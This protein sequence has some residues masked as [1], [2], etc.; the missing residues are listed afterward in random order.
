MQ[1]GL[2]PQANVLGGRAST[3]RATSRP[4]A[5]AR[6]RASARRSPP[7]EF[8]PQL[9]AIDFSFK[10]DCPTDFDCTPP[11]RLPAEPADAARHRLSRQGLRQL[12][13][14]DARPDR[15][16]WR[17]PGASASRQTSAIALV[18][19]LAYVG[20]QIALRARTPRT[21]AYLGPRA[22]TRSRCGGSPA[23]RLPHERGAQRAR[24]RAYR[25]S[26][27]RRAAGRAT[28][29]GDPGGHRIRHAGS[30]VPGRGSPMPAVLDGARAVFEARR[31]LEAA[32][33]RPT[34]AMPSTPGATGAAA[35]PPAPPRDAGRAL[36]NL[37]V[38]DVLVFEE[39]RRAAHRQRPPTPTRPT[40][41][42]AADVGAGLSSSTAAAA[43]RSADRRRNHRDRL[44]R[45]RRA[46]VPAL[47][48][49]RD[50]RGVRPLFTCRGCQRR[51][52][53]HRARR[54]WPDRRGR[55]A[56]R[57]A[58]PALAWA[59]PRRPLRAAAARPRPTRFPPRFRPQLA[60]R[61][62]SHAAARTPLTAAAADAR[63][64]A[65]RAARA[66]P[67]IALPQRARRHADA[68]SGRV[69]DLL[70]SGPFAAHFV[71]EIED[72][73]RA[74]LRFGD[75]MHGLRP[76]SGTT[77]D[78]S[79]RVGNGARRQHRRGHARHVARR[80]PEIAAV[81]NPLPAVGGGEPETH[82]SGA[83]PRALR[84]PP[85]GA[86]GHPRRTTRDGAPLPP[87]GGAS[88]RVRPQRHT[89]SWHTVF[90]TVDRRGGLPVDRGLR[91]PTCARTSSATGW[92]GATSRSTGRATCRSRSSSWSAS[93]RDY[94]RGQVKRRCCGASQQ[95]VL[96]DGR[97]GLFHPDRFSFGQTLYLCPLYRAA[98]RRS[99]G[100]TSV[101]STRFQR[102]GDAG[103]DGLDAGKLRFGR[104]RD[105][106]ARQRP[107]TSPSAAGS[108]SCS[109]AGSERDGDRVPGG[110]CGCCEGIASRPRPARQPAGAC[111]DLGSGSATAASFMRRMLARL[112][113]AEHGALSDLSD[114]RPTTTSRSHCIDAWA[115]VG[116]I[117]TFY[118]ER[119]AAEALL[120]HRERAAVRCT[121][122]RGWSATAASGRRRR[123]RPRL[124]PGAT[125]AGPR[126]SRQLAAR[127]ARCR[128]RPGPGETPV[129]FETSRR[130]ARP[131]GMRMRPRLSQPQALTASDDRLWPAGTRPAGQRRR[132]VSFADRRRR[133]RYSRSSAGRRA[134]TRRPRSDPAPSISRSSRSTGSRRAAPA[135]AHVAP[136]PPPAPACR[137][138]ARYFGRD[139]IDAARASGRTLEAAK[140]G[141]EPRSSHP[142]DGLASR[143][144]RIRAPCSVCARAC[145]ATTRRELRRRCRPSLTGD[146]PIFGT[147]GQGGIIITGVEP[148][149]YKNETDAVGGQHA[150]RSLDERR[151][152][153]RILDGSL[154]GGRTPASWRGA[155]RRRRLGPLPRRAGGRGLAK[156]LHDLAKA[157]RAAARQRRPGSRTLSDPRDHRV[158]RP[159]ERSRWRPASPIPCPA[160]RRHRHRAEQLR[161]RARARAAARADAAGR[162]GGGR[163]VA[164]AEI[165][166]VE[167]RAASSPAAARA[168]RFARRWLATTA[169]TACGSTP[170][171]PRH[172]RREL[173]RSPRQ[174][175]TP[176]RP[177]R[178][179]A[180]QQK[181]LTH[182]TAPV[183]DGRRADARGLGQRHPVAARLRTSSTAAAEER[184]STSPATRRGRPH[185]SS[186][187]ATA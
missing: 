69:R 181:P 163:A 78:A 100:S 130:S 45:R 23:R 165:A 127:D 145:S 150:R 114:P 22:A 11:A 128:A 6:A 138:P 137:R 3:G 10:V 66:P 135:S 92:P 179:F 38:G 44:G 147:D 107:E 111:G 136:P 41:A 19:L 175:A 110:I 133:H 20:D 87:A 79:Y 14:A 32:L 104:L 5:A 157:T 25:R 170:T 160:R 60:A 40:A 64:G 28:S 123:R 30:P 26:S 113:S 121:S 47:P 174:P 37:A 143:P 88:G 101:G 16:R 48:L 29:P 169:A 158:R 15:R 53:Q 56:R 141:D 124:P 77:F 186:R 34:T 1:T 162:R 142:L 105:R 154:P 119:L 103:Q 183:A 172:A 148:G 126:S 82:R 86:R 185:A 117:L 122:W 90:V 27:A 167:R 140:V 115:V 153:P 61:R 42:G 18:E 75:D 132:R 55:G 24:L 2:G 33:R 46:A 146:V 21:E 129:I 131:A 31:P 177:S 182:V 58:G 7:P 152:R 72:D 35:C 106:A 36:P 166:T 13:P 73:G 125:E 173:S 118:A 178:R 151:R 93:R 134:A 52:R 62:V 149:P 102:L 98:R 85:P 81:R 76:T 109:A 171:S 184:R 49:G 155:E 17:R 89:G 9:A 4:I 54:P 144:T 120:P 51:A 99:P 8:D 50:R 176:A 159:G 168:S 71:V 12:P 43:D 65:A 116:D 156:P 39:V 112:S 95:P 94:L 91:A 97:L 84:L 57:G 180:L 83:P 74:V 63:R 96:P 68:V 187:S 67:A 80:S 70:G 108:C 161:A 139:P 164:C 59:P